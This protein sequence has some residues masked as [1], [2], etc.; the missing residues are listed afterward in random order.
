[1]E[2]TAPWRAMHVNAALKRLGVGGED[3]R[4]YALHATLDVKHSRDAEVLIPLVAENPRVAVAI[5]EGALM[6]MAAGARSF[7]RYRREFGL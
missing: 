2:L 3:R 5:A 7:D 6:R 1:M 4:Y